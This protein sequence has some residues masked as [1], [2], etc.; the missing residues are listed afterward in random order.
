MKIK[1]YEDYS[2]YEDGRVINKHGR[3]LK[4][5]IGTHGYKRIG[6]RKDGKQKHFRLHRL[7][8]IHFIVN[9]RPGIAITVDHIDRDKL[10]NSLSNLRWATIEEQNAN[11]YL[12]PIS[13]GGLS[14]NNKKYYKYRW[15]EDKILAQKFEIE[16]LKTYELQIK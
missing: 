5:W 12:I 2:I 7:L 9:T 15:R 8:A 6:L 14:K 13:K 3:E 11:R 10:N 1:G 4:N 16:H